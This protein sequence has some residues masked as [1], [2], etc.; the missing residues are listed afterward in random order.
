MLVKLH[1]IL[2]LR[3]DVCWSLTLGS[4]A[5]WPLEL[6]GDTAA[7]RRKCRPRKQIAK[8]QGAANAAVM[9]CSFSI[10]KR[11]SKTKQFPEAPPPITDSTRVMSVTE[12]ALL[13]RLNPETIRRRIRRGTVRAWGTPWR[14]LIAD[15]IRPYPTPGRRKSDRIRWW[16]GAVVRRIV[17][18][19]QP[20][21]L[22]PTASEI[23]RPENLTQR[24]TRRL[25][26]PAN[27][28]LG[29]RSRLWIEYC[30]S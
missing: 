4:V 17:G 30:R 20:A 3:A 9:L 1:A 28:T 18:R 14:V 7:L 15:L 19:C 8:S 2:R 22:L 29:N 21:R 16:R 6:K 10:T 12:A 23:S 11:K 5:A 27:A 13:T 25:P 26:K 24:A